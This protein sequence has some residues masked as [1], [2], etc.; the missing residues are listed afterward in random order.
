[1]LKNASANNLESI[2][3]NGDKDILNAI[4]LSSL[5]KSGFNASLVPPTNLPDAY[6]I[7]NLFFFS[8]LI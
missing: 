3:K 2:M 7:L 6:V 4:P 8:K 1:M 5:L